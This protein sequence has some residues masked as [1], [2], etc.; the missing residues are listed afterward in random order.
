MAS[1]HPPSLRRSQRPAPWWRSD[2][3]RSPSRWGN[4]TAKSHGFLIILWCFLHLYDDFPNFYDDFPMNIVWVEKRSFWTNG[5][6][7]YHDNFI[8]FFPFKRSIFIYCLWINLG[9]TLIL[10]H[11]HLI[12]LRWCSHQNICVANPTF[13]YHSLTHPNRISSIIELS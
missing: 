10:R 9:Y 7:P 2:C 13:A 4:E 5:N 3:T 8:M 1:W 12:L 6:K 11:T